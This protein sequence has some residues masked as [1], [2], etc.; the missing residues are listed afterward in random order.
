[1]AFKKILVPVDFSDFS[2][3]AVEYAMFLAGKFCAN[4][5]LLHAILL[6]NEDVDEEE[7]LEA[8][9]KIIR[10]KEKERNKHLESRCTNAK[11]RGLQVKSVLIRGYSAADSILNYIDG[12]DFDLVVMGTHGR[13]GLKKLM[14]GSVAERVV[15]LSPI[16]VLTLH[17]DFDGVGLKKI[18]VPV[19]FSEY[20]K[21]ATKHG[22]TIAG[23]FDAAL[24]FLHVVEMKDHPEFY[25]VSFDPILKANPELEDHIVN[26]LIKLSGI[27]K[28]K[29]VYAVSEG[30]V[31]D[32][33]KTYAEENDIDLIVMANHGMSGLGHFL[34]GSN[35]ER[36]VRTAHCPVLTI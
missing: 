31:H 24:E 35:S 23:E 20:S 25:T 7:H 19:D 1:M 33:V 18:L 12:N 3:K 9:E 13:T 26:N 14:L 17:K 27:P 32:Q 4:I 36:V 28:D 30:K 34:S 21:L 6:H 11:D 15:H 22:I 8:Y 2:D 10:E 5:T 29:A 16:P